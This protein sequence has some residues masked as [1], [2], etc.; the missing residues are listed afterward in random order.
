MS[1]CS[2][3]NFKDALYADLSF[4]DLILFFNFIV[5]NVLRRAEVRKIIIR[6]CNV[7]NYVSTNYMLSNGV[8]VRRFQRPASHT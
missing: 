4:G 8:V 6:V 3:E 1:D 2:F 7:T 5:G